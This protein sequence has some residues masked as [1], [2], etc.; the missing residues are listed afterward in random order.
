MKRPKYHVGDD[1][2]I[3]EPLDDNYIYKKIKAICKDEENNVYYITD[4]IDLCLLGVK[5]DDLKCIPNYQLNMNRMKRSVK[6]LKK[7]L[8]QQ[9]IISVEEIIA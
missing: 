1:I 7:E 3:Y 9:N 2:P 8:S 6:K 5:E 4:P